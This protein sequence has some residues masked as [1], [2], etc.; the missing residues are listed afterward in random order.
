[1]QAQVGVER[2]G[3]LVVERCDRGA[4]DDRLDVALVVA[5][6][7]RA[8]CLGYLGHGEAVRAGRKVRLVTTEL[9]LG[10]PRVENSPVGRDGGHAD[11]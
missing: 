9:R 2:I 7:E 10:V 8:D 4:H 1:M 6:L 3:G 11:A 5:A